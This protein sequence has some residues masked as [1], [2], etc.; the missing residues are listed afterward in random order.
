MI[1]TLMFCTGFGSSTVHCL[2]LQTYT[3]DLEVFDISVPA[4]KSF[5]KTVKMYMNHF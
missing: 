5:K 4:P 3:T 2:L 1:Q